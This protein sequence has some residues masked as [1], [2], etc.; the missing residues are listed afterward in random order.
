MK[1]RIILGI[2]TLFFLVIFI[3][4]VSVQDSESTVH[5]DKYEIKGA[6]KGTLHFFGLGDFGELREAEKLS[7]GK[8]AAEYVSDLMNIVGGYSDQDVQFLVTMGDN[9][10]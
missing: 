1:E 10:Y 7:D 4:V 6:G 8:W 3:I 5:I 9:R 2:G